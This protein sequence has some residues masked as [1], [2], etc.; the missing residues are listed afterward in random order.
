MAVII[1]IDFKDGSRRIVEKDNEGQARAFARAA[2]KDGYEC[3][4]EDC[5]YPASEIKRAH[6]VF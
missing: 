3:T 5:Y 2:V 4:N 6:V 1:A